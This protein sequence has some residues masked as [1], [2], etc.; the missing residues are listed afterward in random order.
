[1]TTYCLEGS[2]HFGSSSFFISLVWST[3]L[4]RTAAQDITEWQES[5]RQTVVEKQII[6]IVKTAQWLFSCYSF[7][8][9]IFNQAQEEFQQKH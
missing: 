4:R 9:Y 5:S 3:G 1:M 6:E 8:I 7:H 2:G